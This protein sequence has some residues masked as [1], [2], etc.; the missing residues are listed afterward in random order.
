M[1]GGSLIVVKERRLMVKESGRF[2]GWG[3]SL[4]GLWR[5]ACALR[6]GGL[7]RDLWGRL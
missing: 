5:D 2:R 4:G 6:V 7:K 3:A 1:W